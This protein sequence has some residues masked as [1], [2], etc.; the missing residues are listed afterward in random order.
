MGDEAQLS[1]QGV[2]GVD[3][4]LSAVISLKRNGVQVA[5]AH[6]TQL[7]YTPK[8]PGVYR[9]E[10]LLDYDGTFLPWIYSNPIY[11]K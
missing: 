6:D 1:P 3:L 2:L 10:V 7:R 8:E 11:L 5:E 9:V 4:P